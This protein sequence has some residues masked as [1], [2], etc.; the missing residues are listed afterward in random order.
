MPNNGHQHCESNFH[1][2]NGYSGKGESKTRKI[3]FDKCTSQEN[4]TSKWY[5]GNKE[6]ED[7]FELLKEKAPNWIDSLTKSL[8]EGT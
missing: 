4:L 3:L 5:L 6:Y 8:V 7:A 1:Y 2:F